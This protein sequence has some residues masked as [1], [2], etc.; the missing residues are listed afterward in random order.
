MAEHI[1][2]GVPALLVPNVG[3]RCTLV[4]LA[5]VLRFLGAQDEGEA[6]ARRMG[7]VTGYSPESGPPALAYLALPGRRAALDVAVERVA[8]RC[9]VNARSRTVLL[10][11]PGRVIASLER[12][13]PV[14][15]NMLRAPAGTWSHSVVAYGYRAG[16]RRGA[17]VLTADPNQPAASGHWVSAFRP[18]RMSVVTATFVRGSPS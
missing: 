10:P 1:L 11:A 16:G 4:C 15:L 3:N 12:G 14:V 17:E 18:W 13:M 6:M 2:A 5:T 9:G 8:A 7:A